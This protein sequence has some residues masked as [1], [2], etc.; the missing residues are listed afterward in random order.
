MDKKSLAVTS[1]VVRSRK[2]LSSEIDGETV[3]MS[4]ESGKYY[5]LD[6]VGGRIWELLEKPRTADDI[7]KQLLLDYEV[8]AA[9]CEKD[10]MRFLQQLYDDD[11]LEIQ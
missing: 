1:L 7:S 8:E 2:L 11:L 10:V 4:I 3:M 6:E 5:G 9:A